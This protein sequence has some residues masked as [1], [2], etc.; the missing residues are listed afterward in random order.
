MCFLMDTTIL[1]RSLGFSDMVRLLLRLR[2]ILS[3]PAPSQA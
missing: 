2:V 3:D 1:T